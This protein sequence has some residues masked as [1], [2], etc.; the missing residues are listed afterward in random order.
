MQQTESY[1]IFGPA[2]TLNRFIPTL[3]DETNPKYYYQYESVESGDQ[4]V[5]SVYE[6]QKKVTNESQSLTCVTEYTG[7]SL[8]VTLMPTGGRTGFRGGSSDG[9][10]PVYDIVKDFILDFTKRFGLTIQ[11]NKQEKEEES[12]ENN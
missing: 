6:D 4:V 5:V 11:E 1:V 2:E 12:E 3:A 9:E 7:S 8:K 10:P